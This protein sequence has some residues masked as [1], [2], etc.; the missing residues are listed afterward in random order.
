[1]AMNH[2]TMSQSI[3]CFLRIIFYNPY[4]GVY[5]RLLLPFL[6]KGEIKKRGR[7]RGTLKGWIQ[8]MLLGARQNDRRRRRAKRA[9]AATCA[10]CKKT[11]A[12][13]E[14]TEY[15]QVCCATIGNKG[16]K[17]PILFFAITGRRKGGIGC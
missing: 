15:T 16:L 2:Y 13:T 12:Q 10:N 3:P 8:R 7:E 6:H 5:S 4:C 14:R 11:D 9:R 1:M 17:V